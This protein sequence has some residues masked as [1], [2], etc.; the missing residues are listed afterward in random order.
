MIHS[1]LACLLQVSL[2]AAVELPGP[3]QSVDEVPSLQQRLEQ[4]DPA[5]PEEYFELAEEVAD[6]AKTPE[7]RTLALE[8][9]ALAGQLDFDRLGRSA[10]LAI[11]HFTTDPDQKNRLR[12]AAELLSN[13]GLFQPRSRAG[14][15]SSQE[16]RLL[17]GRMLGAVWA[18][19]I[20]E[21]RELLKQPGVRPLLQK[22]G[23][24]LGLDPDTFIE[25]LQSRAT[26]P[27]SF[28]VTRQLLVEW[29]VLDRAGLSWSAELVASEGRPLT[30]IDLVDRGALLGA[31]V[32]RPYWRSGGW[33]GPAAEVDSSTR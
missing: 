25:Q 27:G 9:F 8:L 24:L 19:R 12:I 33:S 6:S 22:Y 32:T 14:A 1:M 16:S 26:T 15:D 21:A 23:E 13:Q 18:G 20:Q 2:L 3:R 29:T 11:G 28:E 4:L 17:F 31:D 10:I 30:V 7:Q 5:R